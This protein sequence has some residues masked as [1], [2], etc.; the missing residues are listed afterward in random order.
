[1]GNA[2][3]G[4]VI[5]S[6]LADAFPNGTLHLEA[7]AEGVEMNF[8]GGNSEW[9]NISVVFSDEEG[10]EVCV[11][12]L[13][14]LGNR[15]AVDGRDGCLQLS[16]GEEFRASRI[17]RTDDLAY[18]AMP[19]GEQAR[20]L[21]LVRGLS[22]TAAEHFAPM[23]MAERV[24]GAMEALFPAGSWRTGEQEMWF[25]RDHAQQDL[26]LLWLTWCDVDGGYGV[27]LVHLGHPEVFGDRLSPPL[28]GDPESY[29]SIELPDGQTYAGCDNFLESGGEDACFT[30]CFEFETERERLLAFAEGVAAIATQRFGLLPA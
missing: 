2:D 11:C 16:D 4:L 5:M 17:E 10:V 26:P 22:A 9:V 29:G 3:F 28:E 1:M 15:L 6:T 21:R 25:Y 20:F 23:F 7:H 30:C 8:T 27:V 18:W 19:Y 12:P 13:R 14:A 24:G